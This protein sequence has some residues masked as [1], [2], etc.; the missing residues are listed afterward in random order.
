MT[1]AQVFALYLVNPEQRVKYGDE[2]YLLKGIEI[3]DNVPVI[4]LLL[5]RTD[6]TCFNAILSDCSLLL[7]RIENMS[8]E[9]KKKWHSLTNKIRFPKQVIEIPTNDSIDWL[10]EHGYC[11]N[12]DWFNQGWAVEEGK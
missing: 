1:Q 3:L 5:K 6:G 11:T 12:N 2:T 8:E 9:D 7:K 10:R 4:Y